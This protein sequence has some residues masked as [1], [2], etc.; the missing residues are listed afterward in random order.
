M[1]TP[2][3]GTIREWKMNRFTVRVTAHEDFDVDLSWDETDET[4]AALESGRYVNFGAVCTVYLDGTEVGADSIWGCIYK[5]IQ[6][7]QD[8]IEC[9]KYTRELRAAGN[10]ACVGSYF[11]SIINEAIG[12][13]RNHIRQMQPI[14]IRENAT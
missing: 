14:Y 7:F 11:R 5:S 2:S 4:R 6:E 3:I 12:R 9:A 1:N 8:H 13:A 10:Q